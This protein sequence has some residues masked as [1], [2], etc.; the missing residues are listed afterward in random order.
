MQPNADILRNVVSA[1]RVGSFGSRCVQHGAPVNLHK[2]LKVKSGEVVN[3]TKE[4]WKV[5]NDAFLSN[6]GCAN[7]TYCAA[8]HFHLNRLNGE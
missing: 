5:T 3:A 6:I 1:A 8:F 4:R 7:S 2:Q